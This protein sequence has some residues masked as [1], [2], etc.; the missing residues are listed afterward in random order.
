MNR[1]F[2]AAVAA[3]VLLAPIHSIVADD[4]TELSDAAK[5]RETVMEAVASSFGGF[6]AVYLGK[7]EPSSKDKHLIANTRA[8]AIS[9]TLIGDLVPAGSEGGDALPLIWTEMDTYQKYSQDATAATAELARA[10]ESG[11][12]AAMGKAFKAV[13]TSCKTCHDKFREDD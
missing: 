13:G 7:V 3:V 9:S 5:Y 6:I 10:A 4:D 12:R 2:F 11:D 8:L 1:T